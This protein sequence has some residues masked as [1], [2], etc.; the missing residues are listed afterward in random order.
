MLT[1]DVGGVHINCHFFGHEELEF[2]LDPR[3]V[4]DARSLAEVLGFMRQVGVALEL[5]VRLTPENTRE[6]PF[7]EYS[8]GEDRFTHTP[9]GVLR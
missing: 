4:K 5:P 2:D 1:F 8:P 7:L 6:R 9:V 3:E